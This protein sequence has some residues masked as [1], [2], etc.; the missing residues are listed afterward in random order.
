[1][2]VISLRD[3][4]RYAAVFD[5]IISDISHLTF[6]IGHFSGSLFVVFRVNS[7]IVCWP[8]D[9]ND[10]QNHTNGQEQEFANDK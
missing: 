3:R 5:P 2:V 7:W 6:L 1:M 9:E 10:P 8:R 4:R